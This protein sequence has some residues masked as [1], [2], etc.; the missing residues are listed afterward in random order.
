MLISHYYAGVAR[1]YLNQLSCLIARTREIS[2][3]GLVEFA[4]AKW[5]ATLTQSGEGKKI[6]VEITQFRITRYAIRNDV[7]YVEVYPRS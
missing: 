1:M 5:S 2:I 7:I 6:R 3:D 4:I